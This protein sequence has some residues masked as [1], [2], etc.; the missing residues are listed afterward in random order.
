MGVGGW[1]LMV[2]GGWWRLAV[3]GSWRLAVGGPLG[4]SLRAV[5]SKK[6][7]SGPLRTAL[8]RRLAPYHTVR[9]PDRGGRAYAGNPYPNIWLSARSL[10]GNGGNH[11]HGGRPF[12]CILPLAVG[13]FVLSLVDNGDIIIITITDKNG[14]LIGGANVHVCFCC[15]LHLFSG[16]GGGGKGR[17]G[18]DPYYQWSVLID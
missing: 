10:P 15:V 6:K 5:L 14:A 8:A 1:R 4:R 16:E 17:G 18:R 2:A 9:I 11:R 3:D 7:K 12:L 13:R